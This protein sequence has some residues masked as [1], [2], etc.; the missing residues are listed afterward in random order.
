MG[1]GTAPSHTWSAWPWTARTA[2]PWTV[3]WT[4]NFD[5]APSAGAPFEPR[6]PGWRANV[7][8]VSQPSHCAICLVSHVI[9]LIGLNANGI[10]HLQRYQWFQTNQSANG[11]LLKAKVWVWKDW[12]LSIT[13]QTSLCKGTSPPGKGEGQIAPKRLTLAG[14]KNIIMIPTIIIIII[15]ANI[16]WLMCFLIYV[17]VL[18]S[19]LLAASMLSFGGEQARTRFAPKH[20]NL[21]NTWIGLHYRLVT[22]DQ[23]WQSKGPDLKGYLL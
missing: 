14:F 21:R 7:W 22:N 1:H 8:M 4:A 12:W 16:S 17:I 10:K 5:E 13:F 19:Y 11:I 15:N 3:P 9:N 23:A 18:S 6:P 2:A 20:I